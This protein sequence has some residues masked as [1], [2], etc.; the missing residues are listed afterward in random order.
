MGKYILFKVA[1]YTLG[2]LPTPLLY[3]LIE[4]V[5]DLIYLLSPRLRSNVSHNMR[6]VLGLEAS[7]AR[8]R[9]ESRKVFLN[10]AKYYI[11]LIRLP[12]TDLQDFF[13]C[14][15]EYH[16][17]EENLLPALRSGR[18]VILASTHYGNPELAIQ[19]CLCKGIKVF[20]LTEPIQPEQ[21]AR[22]L[23]RLR[24]F[25]GLVFVPVSVSS[26]RQVMRRLNSGEVVALMCDRDIMGPKSLLPFMGAE[27]DMPTGPIELAMRTNSIML[28]VFARRKNGDK[29][30][31][32]LEE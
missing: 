17:F 14:R 28:P 16:G 15:L 27:T 2:R 26:V 18:G 3:R 10:V 21:L 30:E 19:A 22:M 6:Q 29:M 23:N 20:A 1:F 32:F 7:P 12:R 8:I 9:K 5:T 11:D 24:S 31:V 13:Q 4:P 25:H